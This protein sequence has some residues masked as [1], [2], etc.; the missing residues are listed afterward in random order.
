MKLNF[1]KRRI[2]EVK[3][4]NVKIILAKKFENI[5]IPKSFF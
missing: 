5:E 3:S 4:L 1:E 2:H